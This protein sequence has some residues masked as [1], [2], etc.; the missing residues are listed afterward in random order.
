MSHGIV[1]LICGEGMKT[2]TRNKMVV[3]AA[4]L[5]RRRGLN[6]TSV[7]EVVRYT[8]TPRGSISH[9]FPQGKLQLVDAALVFAEQ[10]ASVPLQ[11]LMTELGAIAGLQAFIGLWRQILIGTQ[12]EAGCPV[13]AVAIEQYIGE[14]GNPNAEAQQ[15]LLDRVN[16][17][18]QGWQHS[19]E[20][21]LIQSGLPELRAR[22]LSTLVL[23]SIE[24]TVALCR[25]ARSVDA[26]DEVSDE[27]TWV[28]S[29]A[30]DSYKSMEKC[31]QPEPEELR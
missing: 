28:L 26:L 24:G 1:K 3:G 31:S 18:F 25:A 5:M 17:I 14:D 21:A 15:R 30:I 8:N 12:C 11:K 2:S 4:D 22:R 7:R 23:A 29:T 13:L 19:I 20:T 27:L 6:A 9:H 16:D 10:E